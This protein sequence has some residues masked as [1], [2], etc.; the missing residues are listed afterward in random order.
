MSNRRTFVR[1]C[2]CVAFLV[3][4]HVRRLPKSSY[5]RVSNSITQSQLL[6]SACVATR[7]SIPS[8]RDLRVMGTTK[9]I[10]YTQFDFLVRWSWSRIGWRH[11]STFAKR[12]H[13]VN[14]LI[15]GVEH[16]RWW[17]S[18]T[19]FLDKGGPRST[20]RGELMPVM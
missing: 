1:L 11:R 13:T 5:A 4:S 8:A 12:P 2:S 3:T 16:T 15:T 6:L 9:R 14:Q 17:K 18:T 10:S 19:Y 20:D 7:M